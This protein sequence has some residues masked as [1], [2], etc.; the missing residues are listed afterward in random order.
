M[1]MERGKH[2]L[3]GDLGY[4]SNSWIYRINYKVIVINNGDSYRVES[5]RRLLTLRYYTMIQIKIYIVWNISSYHLIGLI[6]S[7]GIAYYS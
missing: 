6:G 3:Y 4:K 5:D 1:E 7:T 2:L